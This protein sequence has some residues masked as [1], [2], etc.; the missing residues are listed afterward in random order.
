MRSDKNAAVGN[1]TAAFAFVSDFNSCYKVAF[2][3]Q[4]VRLST[5][6]ADFTEKQTSKIPFKTQI[7]TLFLS[8]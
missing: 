6:C 8:L 3:K 4:G 7:I 5:V 1:P 2:E